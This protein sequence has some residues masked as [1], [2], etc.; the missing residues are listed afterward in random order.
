MVL[1][2]YVDQGGKLTQA[3]KQMLA[4]VGNFLYLCWRVKTLKV[5][6]IFL[7]KLAFKS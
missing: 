1:I 5:P 7:P 6:V 2:N 4:M 3:A